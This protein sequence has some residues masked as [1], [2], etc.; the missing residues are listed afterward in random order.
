MKKS[1]N[2]NF[3]QFKN[4]T[5]IKNVESITIELLNWKNKNNNW[6][7]NWKKKRTIDRQRVM[8]S[9]LVADFH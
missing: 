7:K 6:S 8:N 5:T 1:I 4:S 2:E 9:D 3:W